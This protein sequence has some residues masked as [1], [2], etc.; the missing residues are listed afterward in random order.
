M[1]ASDGYRPLSSYALI[2][3]GYTAALV[4]DSASID[5]CCMPRVDSASV[6]GRLLDWDRGG[7]CT[8]E[9]VAEGYDSS[10]DYLEGTLVHVTTFYAEGGEARLYDCLAVTKPGANEPA[11]QLIRVVEG[12]RGS[13]EFLLTVRPRFDYGE[14]EPW[15]KH[16]G[17]KVWSATGGNDSIMVTGDVELELLE[18]HDLQAKLALR[19]GDRRRIA[20]TYYPPEQVEAGVHDDLGPE[21]IDARLQETIDWWR[22]WSGK[23]KVQGTYAPEVKRSAMVL[24]ALV[25]PSTGAVV[26]AP[27]TSLPESIGHP[28]NWDYRYS[29]IRDAQFT[30]R[31][32]T[33]LGATEE[34]DAF[35]SFVERSAAGSA[36]SLQIMY[37]VGGERR[38][39][40]IELG[41]DGYRGTK[42]V[43]IGNAASEQMQLDV[44]G[45]LLDLTWRW[46]QRGRSPDDDYWRFLVSLVDTAAQRW[47]QPDRGLW[48]MRGEPQH[49]V[50]SKA[51]CWA[52]LDRG[53]RLAESCLRQAP[54]DRWKATRDD[55]R[56][57]IETRGYDEQAG[58]YMQAFG[59]SNFDASVLLLPSVDYLPYDHPRMVSTTDAIR[60][61]LSDGGLIRRYRADDGLGG[62]EG[63][64]LACTFWLV[65][66]LAHQGRVEDARQLFDAAAATCN[67][68]GL[69]SEE[70]DVGSR[71]ALGNFPQGLTHLSHIAASVALVRATEAMA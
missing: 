65:E 40:E 63:V 2:G 30:V 34:A 51:M 56:E 7:Y 19:A 52:A 26:A 46:H 47:D 54:L 23:L 20:I 22:E 69:F 41:M 12:V 62:K 57:A 60:R 24:K 42:P 5:W 44:F 13:M 11:A 21:A 68:L 43:R 33:E 49:F 50:H 18:R 37:G 31:S 27:T 3:N 15:I 35:R 9:P 16:H 1:A 70:Y 32:L 58:S 6:F 25:H 45:Y 17:P 59:S 67:H 53:I 71:R 29:W 55:I 28:R 4:S 39:T 36:Q 8:L 48:E 38:L 14:V 10:P 61:E 64:F 66:C